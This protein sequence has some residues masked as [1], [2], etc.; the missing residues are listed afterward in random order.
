MI[1]RP[2]PVEIRKVDRVNFTLKRWIRL[3][4]K[5]FL[6]WIETSVDLREPTPVPFLWESELKEGFY[7]A[8]LTH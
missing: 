5:V 7:W 4:H 1:Y 6:G 3:P 8:D 2:S